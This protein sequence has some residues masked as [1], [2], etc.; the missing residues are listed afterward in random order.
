MICSHSQIDSFWKTVVL[1]NDCESSMRAMVIEPPRLGAWALLSVLVAARLEAARAPA[2]RAM[3]T[4][5]PASRARIGLLLPAVW[6]APLPPAW[7]RGYRTEQRSDHLL[8]S[9]AK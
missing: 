3:R 2:P 7:R 6:P 9:V 1:S 4:S 5:G 8:E